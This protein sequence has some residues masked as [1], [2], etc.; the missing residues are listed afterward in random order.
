MKRR[1]IILDRA[2]ER[3]FAQPP[4]ALAC[5]RHPRRALTPSAF[6]ISDPLMPCAMKTFACQIQAG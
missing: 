5:G 6:A 4:W 1:P 2:L 3:W